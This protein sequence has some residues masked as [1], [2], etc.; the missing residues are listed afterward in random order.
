MMESMTNDKEKHLTL[1]V[2]LEKKKHE[3]NVKH[4][5]IAW[6]Y[7]IVLAILFCGVLAT[8]AI[9]IWG[10]DIYVATWGHIVLWIVGILLFSLFIH[11]FNLLYHIV[12][13]IGIYDDEQFGFKGIGRIKELISLKDEIDGLATELR[14]LEQH[15]SHWLSTEEQY[16]LYKDEL[17][18]AI[19]G[20]QQ[21]ANRNRWTFFILQIIIVACS[22]L[23]G[24]LTS[25]LTNLV[26]IFGNHW[27]APALSFTVSFLTT[28]VTLFRPRE[29]GYNL[30][31]TADAIQFEIDCANRQI[32]DYKNLDNRAAYTRLAEQVEK[33]RNEQRKRQQQLEQASKVKETAD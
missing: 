28:M 2:E 15:Q 26:S 19:R 32:Y 20:Y 29:R 17:L 4:R 3:Y 9:D 23:V 33:L 25:G 8:V 10:Q 14:I 12:A 1:F 7:N 11:F 22:L 5:P 18:R 16:V 31:Q 30:Q 24:G 6:F 21:T 27:I 13:M